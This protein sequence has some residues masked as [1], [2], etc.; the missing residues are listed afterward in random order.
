VASSVLLGPVVFTRREVPDI[1]PWGGKQQLAI[2]KQLGGRRVIDAMGPDPKP[3][4]WHGLFFGPTASTRARTVDALKDAGGQVGLVWGSFAY[5]VVISEF[6]ADYKH[7]WEVAYKITCEVVAQGP[8]GPTPPLDT[9]LTQELAFLANVAAIPPATQ[10]LIT[11]TQTA[12][13]TIAQAQ[14]NKQIANASLAQIQPAI[15]AA[16]AAYNSLL[17]A[18]QSADSSVTGINL[19]AIT[20]ASTLDGIEA[21]ADEQGNVSLDSDLTT[22]LGYMGQVVGNL[23]TA[24]G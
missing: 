17:A 15:V 4:S 23:T 14:P 5:V 24:A 1:M 18:Q 11:A 6:E 9:W 2:H 7:E 8:P 19:D 22:A 21:F 13:N 16:E 12:I 10:T 20:G 3:I